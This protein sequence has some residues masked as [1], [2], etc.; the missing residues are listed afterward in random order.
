[1]RKI[2][3]LT[4]VLV[5]LACCFVVQPVKG[6][7]YTYTLNGP[8]YDDGSV[9]NADISVTIK[10]Y[11]AADQTF[12]MS[13]DGATANTTVINSSYQA[14]S[15]LWN[16]S[17]ALNYTSIY[18]FLDDTSDEVNLYI[19]NPDNVVNLYYFS[20]SDIGANMIDPYIQTSI[21]PDGVNSDVVERRS[22][23]GTA[24]VAFVM[25]QFKTYTLTF[26]CD[27]G[28]YS[29]TFLADI[30]TSINLP[31]LYGAFPASNSSIPTFDAT[32]LNSTLIEFT[33]ADSSSST[34]WLY[35]LVTHKSGTS[36]INDYV[37]NTT[38]YSQ[39][40]DWNYAVSSFDYVVYANASLGGTVFSWQ[41]TVSKVQPD[42]PWEGQLDWLGPTANT[43]P[44]ALMGWPE[45][46][47]SVQV[48]Q[49]IACG[50]IILFLGIGSFRNAGAAMVFAWI[51]GGL[52]MVMGWYT[53]GAAQA[54]ASSIPLFC[55]GLFL[56]IITHMQE[57]KSEG[58][59]L[60]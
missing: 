44:D 2:F 5:F 41:V 45:G 29:Q 14:Q 31:I 40:I 50:V 48:G 33:Y 37:S 9:A 57:K 49:L 30:T 53:G 28:S 3:A 21:T 34:D 39:I 26:I 35:L 6:Q 22:L 23:N 32:R 4:L 24:T 56:G 25:T 7:S 47:S 10:F 38:G 1:M 27:A 52:M 60:S 59:G 12:I 16:A 15:M 42:N 36:T 43:Y 55:F 51:A 19:A 20:I 54:G 18:D 8:Y 46:M 13:G 58:A 17:S 11:G